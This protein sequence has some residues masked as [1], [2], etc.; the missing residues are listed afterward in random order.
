MRNMLTVS[1]HSG[2][3]P[4]Q[5]PGPTDMNTWFSFLS[6]QGKVELETMHEILPLTLVN[7][8]STPHTQFR[9]GRV[10]QEC[11][12]NYYYGSPM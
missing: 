4:Y 8:R 10:K 6:K 9:F 12:C 3:H 1:A 5:L 7:H 2:G 11:D